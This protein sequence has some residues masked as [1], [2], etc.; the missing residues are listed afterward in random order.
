MK[1]IAD[2]FLFFLAYNFLRQSRTR[3]FRDRSSRPPVL[4]ELGVG[5]LVGAFS[6]FLTTPIANV[7]TR[8]QAS[9]ALAE[10][11]TQTPVESSSFRSIALKIHCEKGIR[12][13]WTGCSASSVFTFN[14]SLTFFF[15]ENSK[16]ALLS[17]SQRRDT[18]RQDTFLLAAISKALVSVITF[19]FSLAKCRAQLSSRSVTT[20]PGTK[21]QEILEKSSST[22]QSE[23]QK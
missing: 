17:Q 14:I 20:E 2:S 8:M 22:T 15:F 13:L 5:F 11:S 6:K 12:G 23:V 7:V 3:N 16:R 1:S 9:S 10:R 21:S 19:P 4:H 18:S